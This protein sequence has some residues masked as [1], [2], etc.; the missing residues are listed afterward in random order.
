MP[1]AEAP[2]QVNPTRNAHSLGTAGGELRDALVRQAQGV[3]GVTGGPALP[4]EKAGRLGDR[5]TLSLLGLC[6]G[7]AGLRDRQQGVSGL[8]IVG[9]EVDS[10]GVR[11]DPEQA[12]DGRV[13]V[14]MGVGPRSSLSQNRTPFG[15]IMDIDGPLPV[16]SGGRRGVGDELD[17]G[18]LIRVSIAFRLVEDRV[19]V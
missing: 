1:N 6:P 19:E 12:D 4:G 18:E 3:P 9:R 10:H 5:V 8:R 15:E 13:R 17:G 2:E 16:G 11:L 7:V 14:A